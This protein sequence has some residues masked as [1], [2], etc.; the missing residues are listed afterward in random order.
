MSLV[1]AL[2]RSLALTLLLST[3]TACTPTPPPAAPLD[4]N[5]FWRIMEATHGAADDEQARQ[6]LALR[7]AS[8]PDQHLVDF[9]RHYNGLVDEADRGDLWAAGRL[10]N[11]GHAT[12]DGFDYFREWLVA[13]GHDVYERALA[14]PDS[15]STIDFVQTKGSRA[16]WEGIAYEAVNVYETR[17]Q[18]PFPRDPPDPAARFRSPGWDYRDYTDA[19]MAQRLPRLWQKYGAEMQAWD[20]Q[21]ETAE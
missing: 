14:E 5:T 7:L 17:T 20:R 2:A 13:Q 12:D 18:R 16:E 3:L 8:L 1:H 6:R 15:L 19:V 9:Y 11:G 10:L 21:F 4:R